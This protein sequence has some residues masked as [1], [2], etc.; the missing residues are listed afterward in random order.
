MFYDDQYLKFA[1]FLLTL[2]QEVAK[3]LNLNRFLKK[4]LRPIRKI[5]VLFHFFPCY[6]KLLKVFFV[7]KQRSF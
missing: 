1:I 4:A 7:I 5:P 3:L 2:F 6:Q